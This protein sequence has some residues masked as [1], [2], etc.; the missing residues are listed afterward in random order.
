MGCLNC[1]ETS[2]VGNLCCGATSVL[3]K[4]SVMEEWPPSETS[5]VGGASLSGSLCH[6]G[7]LHGGETSMGGASLPGTTPTCVRVLTR[8]Y[9]CMRACVPVHMCADVFGHVCKLARR[10]ACSIAPYIHVCVHI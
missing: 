8:A 1:R 10:L 7:S 5:L 9:V 2:A 3:G 6:V 4:S